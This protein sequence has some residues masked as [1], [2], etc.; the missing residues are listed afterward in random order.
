MIDKLINKRQEIEQYVVE[1]VD[2]ILKKADKGDVVIHADNVDLSTNQDVEIEKGFHDYIM[3]L[4]PECG[5]QGEEDASLNKDGEYKWVIDP[6]DGTKYY[7]CDIPLWCTTIALVKGDQPVYGILYQPTTGDFYTATQGLGA[8]KN[9]VKMSI[10]KNSDIARSQILLDIGKYNKELNLK[11]I[12]LF[13]VSYRVRILGSGA[14]STAWV[15]NGMFGAFVN[16]AEERSKF[17]DKAAGLLMISEAGG[18]YSVTNDINSDKIT[19]IAGV[20]AIVD[21]VIEVLTN[22]ENV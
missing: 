22:K 8:F 3:N 12:N 17:I 7:H 13:E 18:K 10:G 5:F 14:L 4:F 15:A 6:I 1:L 11:I 21:N 9:G 2:T 16:I 20:P 19:I